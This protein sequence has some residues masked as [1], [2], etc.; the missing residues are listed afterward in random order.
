MSHW[1]QIHHIRKAAD[2]LSRCT[3]LQLKER[4]LD[5]KYRAMSGAKPESLAIPAFATVMETSRRC[6]NQTH[7]DVQLYCGL[8][9]ISGRIAEMKTGEGKTLTA[10]LVAY[11]FG[12]YGR[13]LHVV[14][15][16]D[17]LAQRDC[18]FLRPVFRMLGLTVDCITADVPPDARK[19]AYDCDITYGSAKEFG[20]DFLRDRLEIASTGTPNAGV[21]R[22]TEFALIDEADSI[23]I[24]EARTPLIIGM[25]NQAEEKVNQ[26]C[27][28]WAA[29]HASQFIENKHFQYEHLKQK[30]TLNSEGIRLTRSLTQNEGTTQVSIRQLYDYIQNAIKVR[31]DFHLDKN[32]AI[33]DGE[34]V[35]I[36]EFTGRPAEGRQWQNGIH[37]SVQAKESVDI[38]PATRQ[39]ASITIQSYFK[40]YKVFCGMTGTAWTSKSELSRVYK[41]QVVRIPTH[42]KSLRSQLVNRVFANTTDKF[43]AIARCARDMLDSGRAVLIGTRSVGKSELLAQALMNADVEFQILNARHQEHEAAIIAEAGQPGKVTVA[44]NMAGRG[45]DIKLHPSVQK[46]GGLHVILSEIHESERI[47]WQMI[48]RGAR[49]GDPGSFQIFVSLDDEILTIGLGTEKANHIK[50]KFAKFKG[51]QLDS[52]FA[53]FRKAQKKTERR[54]LT[55]RLMVLKNDLERQKSLFHTGQDPFLYVVSG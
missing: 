42:R 43:A 53:L 17:Y 28:R 22:G 7:Y 38:T 16:N 14:T 29:K 30:A 31:R 26:A 21:M 35:I 11:L 20:F 2:K 33:R 24:D 19:S 47:D 37:Q 41:K 10:G 50:T 34:I 12:L 3:D 52:M 54:Y 40:R 25:V 5:L 15:F 23:L 46:A 4:S 13:G 55:D 32:Y 44:T 8:K 39:A 45:T 48:G 18:D 51:R 36:D 1:S 49:Q 6:L 9:M 27:F